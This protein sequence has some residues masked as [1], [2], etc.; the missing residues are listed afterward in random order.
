M[1]A[2]LYL[3]ETDD[4]CSNY[5]H[6]DLVQDGVCLALGSGRSL[7][8]ANETAATQLEALAAEARKK[9]DEGR[10]PEQPGLPALS[11]R[12]DQW[13]KPHRWCAYIV[14]ESGV[15][16]SM[17]IAHGRTEQEARELGLKALRKLAGGGE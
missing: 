14:P 2:N 5:A 12:H 16:W 17:T 6:V 4:H 13:A 10:V 9:A 7:I 8:K 3:R 11:I 15:Y 1:S